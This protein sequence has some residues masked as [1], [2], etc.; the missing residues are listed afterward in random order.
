[1]CHTERTKLTDRATDGSIY[2]ALVQMGGKKKIQNAR[3]DFQITSI[4]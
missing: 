2:S 4:F 3:I 1:M